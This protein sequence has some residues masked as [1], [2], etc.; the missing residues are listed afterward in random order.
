MYEQGM[1]L[2]KKRESEATR[3]NNNVK[4]EHK[5]NMVLIKNR[6]SGA[7]RLQLN[8]ANENGDRC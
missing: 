6:E 5:L 4:T 2:V 8:I 1:N 3:L 7:T